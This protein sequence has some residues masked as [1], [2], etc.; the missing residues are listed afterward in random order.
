MFARVLIFSLAWIAA[1]GLSAALLVQSSR[2]AP[3]MARASPAPVS[4]SNRLPKAGASDERYPGWTVK[5]AFSAHHVMVVDVETDR[6]AE[7]R[8]I[9]IQIVE[10][11][12]DRYEEV[13]IYVRKPGTLGELATRRVQWTP[14]E[15]Y[16][17][18]IYDT[19]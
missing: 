3:R 1:L 12:R 11:V 19:R 16:V 9:A 2:P 15:G 10:P 17:E 5:R 14:R 18:A 13:L 6:P 4:K 8:R 7:A